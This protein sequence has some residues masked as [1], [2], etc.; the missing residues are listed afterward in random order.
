MNKILAYLG[1]VGVVA[2]TLISCGSPTARGANG[3]GPNPPTPVSNPVAISIDDA[4]TVP[5]FGLSQTNGIIYVHNNTNQAIGNIVYSSSASGGSSSTSLKNPLRARKLTGNLRDSYSFLDLA[6]AKSCETIPANSFCTLYFTTPA[7]ALQGSAVI[8]ASYTFDSKP[9]VFS[10]IINYAQAITKKGVYFTS[11]VTIHNY[12]QGKIG[13]GV[14][15]VYGGGTSSRY[16]IKSMTTNVAS[17]KITQNN[18]TGYQLSSGL[19]QAVEISAMFNGPASTSS[20]QA[21]VGYNGELDMNAVGV[22]TGEIYSDK[23][24]IGAYPVTNGPILITGLAPLIDTVNG[25]VESGYFPVINPGNQDELAASYVP[26]SNLSIDNTVA[27]PCGSTISI[28]GSCNLGYKIE[29]NVSS[30]SSNITINY[31]NGSVAQNITWYNSESSPLLELFANGGS[32]IPLSGLATNTVNVNVVNVGGQSMFNITQSESIPAGN[33]VTATHSAGNCAGATLTPFGSGAS[34]SCSY[35]ESLTATSSASESTGFVVLAVDASYNNGTVQSYSRST[36]ANYTL[37]A[38]AAVLQITPAGLQHMQ[39]AGNNSESATLLL[40]VQNVGPVQ[41]TIGAESFSPVLPFFTKSGACIS[42]KTLNYLESCTKT[43]V[44]GPY[45]ESANLTTGESGFE[46]YLVPYSGQGQTLLGA[47]VVESIAYVITPNFESITI[48]TPIII[49]SAGGTGK[50]GDPILF[51]G[52]VTTTQSIDLTYTNQ[53]PNAVTIMG[54]NESNISSMMWAMSGS[55]LSQIILA[56][57]GT[58]HIVYTNKLKEGALAEA[59]S[60]ASQAAFIQNINLPQLVVKDNVATGMQFNYIPGFLPSGY[61]NVNGVLYVTSNQATLANSIVV[62]QGATPHTVTVNNILTNAGGFAPISVSTNM[63]D[64]FYESS[65]YG[66]IPYAGA[67]HSGDSCAQTFAE[68]SIVNMEC[69]LAPTAGSA[70]AVMVYSVDP[71]FES[72]SSVVPLNT[73]FKINPDGQIVGMTP[74]SIITPG[75]SL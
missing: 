48:G 10:Q 66:P 62:N 9:R 12:N 57:G 4:G 30:G 25:L 67:G 16:D 21:D 59:S 37:S 34:S 49:G 58:C 39:I 5:L 26:G 47:K 45:N 36:I 53:G 52:S 63:E 65:A 29:S 69:T 56:V 22:G 73:F 3:A 35:T 2:T 31:S 32:T 11:G 75:S 40:T 20:M 27:T 17:M 54:V 18:L 28:G 38:N 44:L 61:D 70:T 71:R 24:T 43:I 64:Y 23:A 60:S 46:S 19:V 6:R 42:G 1:V 7:G 33:H 55:C 51:S 13:Y 50:S 68:S 72:G 14:V 8:K 41:G 74:L 15:Y